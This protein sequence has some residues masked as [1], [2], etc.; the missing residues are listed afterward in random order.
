MSKIPDY[1]IIK[2][3]AE[4]LRE[5]EYQQELIEKGWTPPPEKP[6]PEF[7]EGQPVEV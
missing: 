7:K 6:E 3:G 1:T 5:E 2:G 4:V